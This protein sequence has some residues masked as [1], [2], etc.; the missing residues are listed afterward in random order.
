MRGDTAA[1]SPSVFDSIYEELDAGLHVADAG[2]PSDPGGAG[3]ANY[4]NG[5]GGS[6]IGGSSNSRPGERGG[7][8][9]GVV[10]TS[11][12]A[13]ASANAGSNDPRKSYMRGGGGQ[14]PAA[15]QTQH[16]YQQQQQQR[17][18]HPSEAQAA[19]AQVA[20]ANGTTRA[21]APMPCQR[22]PKMPT[23]DD[24][25]GSGCAAWCGSGRP[26]CRTEVAVVVLVVGAEWADTTVSRVSTGSPPRTLL[27]LALLGINSSSSR[28]RCWL[29]ETWPVVSMVSSSRRL[30]GR[31]LILRISPRAKSN[32]SS[33]SSSSSG[34]FPEVTGLTMGMPDTMDEVGTTLDHCPFPVLAITLR[35]HFLPRRR[36]RGDMTTVTLLPVPLPLHLPIVGPR[37]S[38]SAEP[39][40]HF[41]PIL[42][43]WER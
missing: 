41:L 9:A 35:V 12:P 16:M 33:S 14:P 8:A 15:H 36:P 10:A 29:S 38:P 32:P 42:P 39:I 22:R 43:L 19:L 11:N 37:L 20:K 25:P 28:G 31:V 21:A 1:A 2:M 5:S 27:I 13:A 24:W 40:D 18:V 17:T 6:G 3:R 30:G 23:N 34:G 7:G 4:R 26:G